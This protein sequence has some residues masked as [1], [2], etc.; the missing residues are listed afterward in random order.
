MSMEGEALPQPPPT[1]SGGGPSSVH[2]LSSIDPVCPLLTDMYQVSRPGGPFQGWS[3][4]VHGHLGRG[5]P[6]RDDT[7]HASP[8][9]TGCL[10]Q[11]T[12]VYGY[13]KQGRHEEEAVFELFFRKTPFHGEFA[14]FAGLDEVR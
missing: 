11:I 8:F 2:E 9:L 12:M 5:H 4:D 3:K 7:R 1:A 14:I 10:P 13:W 6:R